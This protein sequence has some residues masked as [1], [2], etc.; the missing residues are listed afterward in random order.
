MRPALAIVLAVPLS[1]C[2][3][4]PSAAAA[5]P[6]P[7]V[8]T[9]VETKRA[10]RPPRSTDPDVV[11]LRAALDLGR[12]DEARA[13][14][15]RLDEK[16]IGTEELLLRARFDAL[17]GNAVDAIRKVEAARQAAPTDPDVFATASEI[18]AAAGKVDA[19]WQ[20]ERAGERACGEAPELDR[21]R[22]CL[23]LSR[24]GGARKGLEL[25]EGARKKDPDLPFTARA[26]SQAHLL[27]GKEDAAARK[28]PSAL[29]HAQ[30]AASL[31]PDDVDAR[32]FLSEALL[33]NGDFEGGVREIEALVEKGQPLGAE[34]AL[35]HKKAGI[36]ALLERDRDRAIGHFAAARK[37]GLTDEELSTGAR[38][39]AEEA[40]ARVEKGIEAYKA[41]D[42]DAARAHFTAALELDPDRIE[43][44]NHLA[45][46]EFKRGNLGAAIAY[47]RS[48]LETSEK[49][50]LELPEPVHVNLA[51]ALAL[52]G[53]V[54][55]A[56]DLLEDY[57]R[58]NP[59][60]RFQDE[61]RA[62]L[63]AL[64]PK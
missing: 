16:R 47:W 29:E 30:L 31:D 57:L 2:S 8:E 46:V 48:V 40:A 62:A 10:A 61:T 27:V 45:V 28:G 58:K 41:G 63:D 59:E 55:A 3:R 56:R 15:P 35:L 21:A 24:S 14:L 5:A 13:L 9:R 39:L 38:V 54:D 33:L 49:E 36:A 18:Y 26:L 4:E 7:A 51:K 42:L 43:A 1:G 20:E 52:S 19:G 53:E 60:G 37:L 22:A 64:P 11:R 44:K 23:W 12:A 32:R 17:S 25:L 34:L 50:G 6:A